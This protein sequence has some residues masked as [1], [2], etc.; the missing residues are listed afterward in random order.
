MTKFIR[1]TVALLL[2][3]AC[4]SA[5]TAPV[6]TMAATVASGAYLCQACVPYLPTGGSTSLGGASSTGGARAT[7]GLAS[8]G[9]ARST[10]GQATTG[11]S[12]AVPTTAVVSFPPCNSSAEH[13]AKAAHHK[14]HKLGGHATSP[15]KTQAATAAVTGSSVFWPSPCTALDQGEVGSCTGN[16]A[17]QT[18]STPPYARTC[19]EA[20]ETA[21]L[22]CYSAATKIDQGCAWNAA[23]CANSYPPT[24]N[25]SYATSAYAAATYMGWFTGTRPVVQSLQG[26]HDA[27]LQGPCGFDQNWYNNG[28]TPSTCGEVL[29]T[30]G[31]AGGHSTSVVGYD[32]AIGRL[33]LRNSW[34]DWG[35]ADGYYFYSAA[36]Q[37]SLLASGAVMICPALP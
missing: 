26:W 20:D 33:W 35:V 25:G 17:T 14:R 1:A 16:D 4:Q 29:L 30:G 34:G 28:F 23:T 8:T 19:A 36:S 18:S 12:S 2:A 15:R 22:A 21:A 3:F 32:V 13:M 27:L 5:G 24:D 11:G 10:G 7:G 9:G 6:A 31:L 37:K